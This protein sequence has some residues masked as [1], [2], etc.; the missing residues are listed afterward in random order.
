MPPESVVESWPVLPVG[1]TSESVALQQQG[2]ATT[3]G[4]TDI[5]V[6]IATWEHVDV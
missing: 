1:D 2:S 5:P 6:C 3:K 4:Q